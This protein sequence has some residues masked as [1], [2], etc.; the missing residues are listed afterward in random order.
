MAIRQILSG[1]FVRTMKNI[2]RITLFIFLGTLVSSCLMPSEKG[3]VSLSLSSSDQAARDAGKTDETSSVQVN[4]IQLVNDQLIISGSDLDGVTKALI[5]QSGSDAT[6][7]IISQ[8]ASELILSSSTQM[9]LALNTLMSLTL[10]DAYGATVI[11]VT[12]NLPDSSVSTAKIGDE[13]VTTAKI[14]NGAITAVKLSSMSASV[15]QLLRWNGTSWVASDLDAL[16]YAGTWNASGNPNPSAVGGEYYIVTT[17]GSNVD[18]GDGNPRDWFQ[19]DWIVYNDNTSSWDQIRNSSDVT[20]FNTRTGAVMPQA[21]DY[22]WA[23]IDKTTSSIGDIADVDFTTAPTTGQVLKFDGTSWIADTDNDSGVSA[24]SVNSASIANDSI[25]DADINSAAAI[26]WS[27]INKT[28]AT[29]SDVG[30]GNVTNDAQL[31]AADL[32]T[33]ATL[34]TDDT[35]IPSQN[36]VKTYVDNAVTGMGS[37]TSITGGAGLTDGPITTSGTLDVN[38]DDSTIE[39]SSDTLQLKD[40]GITNA[41]INSS[42]AIA[43]S[44]ID[45]T[46]ASASDVGLGNVTNDAQLKASDLDTT[47]TLGTSDTAIPSQNAV[48]TYVD[49]QV[50]GVNQSQWTTTGSDI[51]YN[52]GNIGLGVSSPNS[53]IDIQGQLNSALSGTV[54]VTAGTNTLVGTGTSFDTELKYGDR[55]IIDGE[56]NAVIGVTDAT[57]ATLQLN[58]VAGASGVTAYKDSDYLRVRKSSGHSVMKIDSDGNV[59]IGSA[60]SPQGKLHI[61]HNA[62]GGE[63]SAGYNE[64]VLESTQTGVGM[65]ILSSTGGRGVIAFGDADNPEMGRLWYDNGGDFFSIHTNASEKF[66][67]LSD[68]K[69]GIGTT[70]PSTELEVNGTI[71]A[72]GFSGPITSTT[73]SVG[74]GS[75]AAPSYTFSGDTDTGFYSGSADTI[76]VSVNG[77]NIFDLSSAGLVSSAAGGG[78]VTTANGT[79]SNPTFSFSGDT[80]TGWYS[81]LADNLA[82]ATAGV[83]RIRI[84]ASGNIGVGTNNPTSH[85]EVQGSGDQGVEIESTDA[86]SHSFVNFKTPTDS[87]SAGLGTYSIYTSVDTEG[88]SIDDGTSSK[89]FIDSA[90]HVGLGYVRPT[91]ELHFS[92]SRRASGDILDDPSKYKINLGCSVQQSE[93][94][95]AQRAAGLSARIATSDN[96]FTNLTYHGYAHEF[97][98]SPTNSKATLLID[99]ESYFESSDTAVTINGHNNLSTNYALKVFN[100]NDDNLFAL[101]N[102]GDLGVG[103][104]DPLSRLHVNEDGV[105]RS[106]LSNVDDV[107]MFISRDATDGSPAD[108]SVGAA[109]GFSNFRTSNLL[110]SAIA[111]KQ[112]SPDPDVGALGFFTQPNPSGGPLVEMMTLHHSGLL[113]LGDDSPIAQLTIQGST[114]D[115]L[116]GTVSVTAGTNAVVGT[117]TSFDTQLEVGDSVAI[118]GEIFKVAAITDA[119]N[120]T[121]DSNHIAGAASSFIYGD[122]DLVDVRKGDGDAVFRVTA[123]G[124]VGIGTNSPVSEL[125]V[126]GTITA[127]QF[128]G[129][130]ASSNITTDGGTASAPG[131]AFSGD[132]N[133]GLFSS[134]AD[135]IEVTVGG[136]NIFDMSSA[137]LVS[138]TSG[139]GLVTSA[140]GTATDPTF[141][142]AGDSDTGWYSP[143]ADTLAAATAGAERIRISSTGNI[144]IGTTSPSNKLHVDGGA[145]LTKIEVRTT[146]N[147]HLLLNGSSNNFVVGGAGHLYFQSANDHIFRTNS[148]ADEELRLSATQLLKSKNAVTNPAF[149]FSGD[150]DTGLDSPAANVLS[151]STAGAESLR[152]DSSGN[153]GIGTTSPQAKLHINGGSTYLNTSSGSA[154]LRLLRTNSSFSKEYVDQQVEDGSYVFYYNN[155]EAQSTIH[156]ETDNTDTESGGGASANNA[157]ALTLLSNISGP[158]VGINNRS[159]DSILH[160]IGVNPV[161]HLQ[162]ITDGSVGAGGTLRFG[163]SQDSSDTP[164]GEIRGELQN[165]SAASRAG[166]LSFWTSDAGTLSERMRLS[167]EGFLGIGTTDP[168]SDFDVYRAS[169][170]PTYPIA[171]FRD[172]TAA[173]NFSDVLISA[174]RP[175]LVLEDRSTSAPDLRVGLDEGRVYFSFDTDDDMVKN[176]NSD[177]DDSNSM[178]I[179][180][181]SKVG[182]GGTINPRNALDVRGNVHI[183]GNND[184]DR[185]NT[186]SNIDL[187]IDDNDSGINVPADGVLTFWTNNSE[188]VRILSNGNMGIATTSPSYKLDVNG[189]LRGFGITDSSDRRLKE[190]ITPL[191]GDLEKLIQLEGVSYY[192]R[193]R[194]A[195]SDRL[196]IGVIAQDVEEVYPELVSTDDQGWKSVNYSHFIAPLIEGLKELYN[197]FL[198][199]DRII[200]KQSREIASL[201]EDKE[202]MREELDEVKRKNKKLEEYLCLKDP[203]AGFCP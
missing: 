189:T 140:A 143:T 26:S 53:V 74:A 202:S 195:H 21:G 100:N 20:S 1:T 121:L 115:R 91:A 66:R 18:P 101:D 44:K 37:V 138:N 68:G 117:A 43:W 78:V 182:I 186:V 129:P 152:I 48:K 188:K 55:I 92:S 86:A 111:Y 89:L 51:Y 62:T 201:K 6:L 155:D 87:W 160:P 113:G 29:G 126:N 33:T 151:L 108:G 30:L 123:S 14:A 203:N 79:V 77:T 183:E 180:S 142:F 22:T 118:E 106:Q 31:K 61:Q 34:G 19:G 139:G 147:A 49:A 166:E 93:C 75:A 52:T 104:S 199:H 35:K 11:D 178:T 28:G 131:Y 54:S 70:T 41:K 47:T 99:S 161:I 148:Q 12:F 185:Y 156:F 192:W 69:V 64:L 65:N 82:A 133:T 85:L 60:I 173:N 102:S 23:Q 134:T 58:H 84:D 200:E 164:I 174:F 46:G 170:T 193:D 169:I 25:V 107:T 144:G 116:S 165:G 184:A 73:A 130:I 72:S 2:L 90:G 95:G 96:R 36:A 128:S 94:K 159:P 42:A 50:T 171:Q 124:D 98:A 114:R 149:S 67:I 135:T 127:D 110:S 154:P 3:K 187:G 38:V 120:M 172:Y 198:G 40:D 32:D 112:T 190:E 167:E 157:T 176:A 158:K 146:S 4:D 10:E 83:E 8:T 88:F 194:E 59:G 17:D 27:K 57:T 141:S 145:G 168:I 71:T 80:D 9:A 150:N 16:T 15:G 122:Y 97:F 179:T 81:P 153:V 119:N 56:S 125:E 191:K 181:D 76:E 162:N 7:S 5:S 109:L 24:D 197:K 63:V 132:S 163:H 175:G 39:V 105:I 45:K 103:I 177:F 137:G 196:Q 13:Q 136:S